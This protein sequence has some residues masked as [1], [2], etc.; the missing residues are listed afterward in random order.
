MN[1]KMKKQLKTMRELFSIFR[2]TII[3]WLQGDTI[4]DAHSFAKRIVRGFKP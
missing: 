3:Y 2:L 4:L 1:N